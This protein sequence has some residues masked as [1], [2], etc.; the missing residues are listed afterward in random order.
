MNRAAGCFRGFFGAHFRANTGLLGPS[1]Q[2]HQFLGSSL[3]AR[4]SALFRYGWEAAVQ[5]KLRDVGDGQGFLAINPCAGE[6]L[7]QVAEEDVDLIGAGE[8]SGKLEQFGGEGFLVGL[9]GS[10]PI[11]MIS[12]E[13]IVTRA[14]RPCHSFQST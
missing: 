9:G 11:E 13:R 4:G 2:F 6:L 5:K 7:D 14:R 12:A 8:T 1:Q 10:G 3:V